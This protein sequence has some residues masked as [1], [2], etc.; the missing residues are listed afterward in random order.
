MLGLN[1][2]EWATASRRLVRAINEH[3]E[4]FHNSK[5]KSYDYAMSWYYPVLAGIVKG[6]GAKE[7]ILSQWS[8]FIIEDWGCKCV[9]EAPWWVTSAETCELIMALTRIGEH[10]RARLLLDWILRLQDS[11]GRFWTGM[12]IPEEEVWPPGQKPTWVSAALI[13]A[14]TAQPG[15]KDAVGIKFWQESID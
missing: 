2:P 8:D 14:L 4:L 9:V 6:K 3:P 11:D 12:K 5:D 13:M 7:R 1:K 15:G 10:H